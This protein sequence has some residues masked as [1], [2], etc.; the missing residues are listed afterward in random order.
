MTTVSFSDYGV[1]PTNSAS[2]NDI[3]L[4][5]MR[6]ALLGIQSTTPD[7]KFVIDAEPGTYQYTNN[8]WLI[9]INHVEVVGTEAKFQNMNASGGGFSLGLSLPTIFR[10]VDYETG[11]FTLAQVSAIATAKAGDTLVCLSDPTEVSL[12]PVGGR[13]LIYGFDQQ[14]GGF[15]PNARFFEWR[16]VTEVEP[17]SGTLTLDKPLQFSYDSRWPDSG[18]EIE[19]GAGRILSLDRAGYLYPESVTLRGVTFIEGAS[20]D[21]LVVQLSARNVLFDGVVAGSITPSE[22]ESTETKDCAFDS[23]EI[24]K[25]L[26][27]VEI[28]SCDVGQRI[29]QGTGARSVIIDSC[30]FNTPPSIAMDVQSRQLTLNNNRFYGPL[31]S[32]FGWFSISSI[33]PCDKL[34]VT[35]NTIIDRDMS[36]DWFLALPGVQALI[37]DQVGPFNNI[38]IDASDPIKRQTW[39]SLD[40]GMTLL[41]TGINASDARNFGTIFGLYEEDGFLVVEGN[42]PHAPRAGQP[43]VFS[44]LK[45]YTVDVGNVLSGKDR[46]QLF[47]PRSAVKGA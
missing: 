12:Y 8:R 47:S 42:W 23:M 16:E 3:A 38:L 11:D 29:S 17:T 4:G 39:R 32:G 21:S 31:Q 28:R 20:P 30:I 5:N 14:E 2:Q 7:V 45:S 25:L 44:V 37:V 24:D 1:L 26:V 34:S 13:I 22:S 41:A 9:G 27:K 18:V 46:F 35:S 19:V 10:D 43:W 33:L 36:N 15:P 6:D 40:Y